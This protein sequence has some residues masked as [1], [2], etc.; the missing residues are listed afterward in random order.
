[1][2]CQGQK[3]SQPIDVTLPPPVDIIQTGYYFNGLSDDSKLKLDFITNPSLG[4]VDVSILCGSTDS[5][6]AN[7]GIMSIRSNVFMHSGFSSFLAYRADPSNINHNT[8]VQAFNS[9]TGD[10]TNVVAL[11]FKA[12][13]LNPDLCDASIVVNAGNYAIG[14]LNTGSMS[15]NAGSQLILGPLCPDIQIG[16][17][18]SYLY[19]FGTTPANTITLGNEYT[20][21]YIRG[22]LY[23]SNYDSNGINMQNVNGHLRQF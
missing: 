13:S 3:I 4:V 23:L 18:V 14:A 11:N 10:T 15:L 12:S 9:N 1:V 6:V 20:T 19:S 22:Q 5:T 21:V 17:N 16:G 2:L 7:S 8:Y